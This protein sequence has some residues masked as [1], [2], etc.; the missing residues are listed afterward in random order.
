MMRFY[1]IILIILGLTA[2]NPDKNKRA[3][4]EALRFG[5]T[6]DSEIFFR[7]LRQTDYD[8]EYNEAANFR[9]YRHEDWP[10]SAAYPL[11]KPAI[12]HNW[13][14]S[15]AYLLL[16]PNDRLPE[17]RISIYWKTPDEQ[18]QGTYSFTYGSKEEHLV[19][20]GKL[21]ESLLD[22]HRLFLIRNNDTLPFL[23]K[24]DD[25]EAFR[26]TLLDYYRLTRNIK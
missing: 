26:I 16:E 18:Q 1:A 5:T 13:R 4:P 15:M 25:R 3:N 21:Y 6:D 19:F 2:C 22:G 7:N 8:F 20:A 10:D 24:A 12:V 17:S 9:V 23:D 11:L 14:Q